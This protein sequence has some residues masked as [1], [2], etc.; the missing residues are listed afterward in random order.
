MQFE[1][2]SIIDLQNSI[3]GSKI[4]SINE[5]NAMLEFSAKH[6][7]FPQVEVIDFADAQKGFDKIAAG[8][9]RYRMVLKI[10]GFREAQA[11]KA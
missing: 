11:A 2:F 7:C 10:E 1:P 4:G 6:K 8:A 9:P 3:I 5:M